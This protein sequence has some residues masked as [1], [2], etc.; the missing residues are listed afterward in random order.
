MIRPHL[1][2]QH[3][4]ART[5][6]LAQQRDEIDA[7]GVGVLGAGRRGS[8]RRDVQTAHKIA[9]YSGL[10]ARRPAHEVRHADPAVPRIPLP[11]VQRTVGTTAVDVAGATVVA[12]EEDERVLVA[13]G[14]LQMLDDAPDAIVHRDHHR[15]VD[16]IEIGSAAGALHIL[17][18]CL[19]RR[20]R[21][22]AG[23]IEEERIG[24]ARTDEVDRAVGEHIREIAVRIHGGSTVEHRQSL[25]IDLRVF[26]GLDVQV[27]GT[28]AA[29][30]SGGPC[31]HPVVAVEAPIQRLITR[32][33][34]DMPLA[35]H[36][37]AV[38]RRLH[39]LRDQRLAL[40]EAKRLVTPDRI[41]LET[42]P[43][44]RPPGEQGGSGRRTDGG[45]DIPR[46]HAGAGG[47]QRVEVRRRDASPVRAHVAVAHVV[48]DDH[49]DIG[50]GGLRVLP[51]RG[52]L[53]GRGRS[54]G[55]AHA[56]GR[57]EQ[58]G[59]QHEAMVMAHD[60]YDLRQDG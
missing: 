58:R 28:D 27:P 13:A 48:D 57:C 60:G 34:P 59:E 18:G 40:V 14:P 37:R 53:R 25:P 6:R 36:A 11:G 4:I 2:E 56:G 24:A 42:E 39:G 30:E 5:L 15:G 55:S 43:C 8:G 20:M 45:G 52:T 9:A 46:G 10:D 3:A 19:Q 47:G 49:D 33:L 26:S 51:G 54:G 35:H 1:P 31:Q 22:R 21:R 44:L 29:Q 23:E 12:H 32:R 50:T 7:L 16:A 17:L 38:T 41:E